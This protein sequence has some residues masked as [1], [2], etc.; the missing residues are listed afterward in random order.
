MNALYFLRKQTPRWLV[1]KPAAGSSLL[2]GCIGN[3]HAGAPWTSRSGVLS[4]SFVCHTTGHH[5]TAQGPTV[6]CWEAR[7]WRDAFRLLLIPFV[8][9]SQPRKRRTRSCPQCAT[10][11]KQKNTTLVYL[12]QLDKFRR[13][14]PTN[15]GLTT[16]FPFLR[17][18]R[19][20]TF[21][22]PSPEEG[23]ACSTLFLCKS[24]R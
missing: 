7:R 13:T 24:Y 11:K 20:E 3:R 22:L 18:S 12:G 8:F 1:V 23:K 17:G 2:F 16:A 14:R 5:V 19:K 6:I 9:S 21:N 4:T 15:G 10:K